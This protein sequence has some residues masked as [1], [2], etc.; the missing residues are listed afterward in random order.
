MGWVGQ[1]IPYVLHEESVAVCPTEAETVT[2]P[3]PSTSCLGYATEPFHVTNQ[4]ATDLCYATNFGRSFTREG[5]HEGSSYLA[6]AGKPVA[7]SVAIY[8]VYGCLRW[9]SEMEV[10]PIQACELMGLPRPSRVP[11]RISLQA[12]SEEGSTGYEG[13]EEQD[14]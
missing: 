1:T 10:S 14:G 8:A 6:R 5:K 4:A 7:V 11:S 12:P 3:A 13:H 9:L 2:M